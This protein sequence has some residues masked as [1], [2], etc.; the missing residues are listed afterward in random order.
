MHTRG[1]IRSVPVYCRQGVGE[2]CTHTHTH[3]D[4]NIDTGM[5]WRVEE[6]DHT[7]PLA[8]ASLT[9]SQNAW[10]AV[11]AGPPGDAGLSQYRPDLVVPVAS[12][13]ACSGTW[14]DAQFNLGMASNPSDPRTRSEPPDQGDRLDLRALNRLETL[15]VMRSVAYLAAGGAAVTGSTSADKRDLLARGRV[16]SHKSRASENDHPVVG[17]TGVHGPRGLDGCTAGGCRRLRRSCSHF[18][19]N[20]NFEVHRLQNSE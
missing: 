16:A 5:C 11:F 4:E 18:P 8:V 2:A 12:L 19:R 14:T 13:M 10:N 9:M 1:T 20:M 7:S 6:C 15:S 17:A 3:T